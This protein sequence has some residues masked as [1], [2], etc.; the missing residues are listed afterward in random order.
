M[1]STVSGRIGKKGKSMKRKVI[2]VGIILLLVGT[3]IIPSS[4]QKIEK[5]SPMASRGHWLYVGGSG[6]GNYTKI[7]DAIDNASDGDTVFVYDDSAPY[8]EHINISKAISLVG[9]N[10]K[11]TVTYGGIAI[12]G[13]NIT[14]KNLTVLNGI[15]IFSND[16]TIQNVILPGVPGGDTAIYLYHSSRTKILNSLVQGYLYGI[17]AFQCQRLD[18]QG[19]NFIDNHYNSV[20][21][22]GQFIMFNRWSRNY[23]DDWRGIGPYVIHGQTWLL[24]WFNFDW[25]P[26]KGP[27]DI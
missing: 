9:E 15:G 13:D 24:P 2:V 19:N 17:D 21:I 22:A 1:L 10:R 20:F 11:T 16:I 12:T 5:T 25:H 18:V 14:V 3:T 4:G 27:Y 26:A 8:K 6:P 23:W 7:Q